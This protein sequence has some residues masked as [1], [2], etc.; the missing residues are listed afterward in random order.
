MDKEEIKRR[1]RAKAASDPKL[2]KAI[3]HSEHVKSDI[4]VKHSEPVKNMKPIKESK[5]KKIKTPK[6]H[7]RS[8]N[9]LILTIFVVLAAVVLI[10]LTF[11]MIKDGFSS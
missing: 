10:G 3:A 4:P 7:K 8:S 2:Q 6:N 5:P 9:S 11:Y 1:L